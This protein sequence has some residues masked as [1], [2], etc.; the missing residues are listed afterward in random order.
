MKL[1]TALVTYNNN[2]ISLPFRNNKIS[3]INFF[4]NIN[5]LKSNEKKGAILFETIQKKTEEK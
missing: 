4:Y 2:V 5:Y 3:L 1:S